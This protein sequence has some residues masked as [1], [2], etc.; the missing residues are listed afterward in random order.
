MLRDLHQLYG[1]VKVDFGGQS[2]VHDFSSAFVKKSTLL[3]L[4][5][6]KSDLDSTLPRRSTPALKP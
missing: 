6:G 2:R 1:F 4:K 5:L 3:Y